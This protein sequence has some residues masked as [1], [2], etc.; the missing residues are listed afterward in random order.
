MNEE[1]PSRYRNQNQRPPARAAGARASLLR[2]TLETVPNLL[3]LAR[4]A[5]APALV[6]LIAQ[7]WLESAFWLFLL[8]GLSDA[9]DGPIARRL[10]VAS[11]FGAILDP[12]ADKSVM[13]AVY[14]TGGVCGLMP[15][16]L[17]VLVVA[18]DLLILLGGLR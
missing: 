14:A 16:W 4:L 10:G 8:A 2:R 3:G 5:S 11:R 6:W 7:G 17:V 13:A 15:I 12:L 1:E 18:R 9:I